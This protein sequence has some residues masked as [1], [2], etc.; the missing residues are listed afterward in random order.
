[1]SV[2]I[3]LIDLYR[4]VLCSNDFSR[5]LLKFSMILADFSATRIRFIGADPDPKHCFKVWI[6]L[7]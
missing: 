1:M 6:F 5:F 2:N 7:V 4:N 3:S